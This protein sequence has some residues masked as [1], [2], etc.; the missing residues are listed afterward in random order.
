MKPIFFSCFFYILPIINTV[1]SEGKFHFIN[2]ASIPSLSLKVYDNIFFPNLSHGSEIPGIE[3]RNG[4]IV[5][6]VIHPELSLDK[7]LLGSVLSPNS[8]I[9]C[10]IGDFAI[11]SPEEFSLRESKAG[12]TQLEDGSFARFEF[13]KIDEQPPQ[14]KEKQIIF[15][16]ALPDEEIKVHLANSEPRVI[17]YGELLVEAQNPAIPSKSALKI[18]D[19][20]VNLQFFYQNYDD[21]IVVVFYRDPDTTLPIYTVA[22][23]RSADSFKRMIQD[24]ESNQDQYED[25][26]SVEIDD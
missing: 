1:A 3:I 24:L 26:S 5:L 4:K 12:F 18:G 20:D 21:K 6:E 16:N 14:S 15:I 11:L 2:T 19:Q 9:V 17:Q 10:L 7:P 13:L 22:R 25:K 8:S 23:T